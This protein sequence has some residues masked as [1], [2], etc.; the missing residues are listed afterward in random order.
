MVTS[1]LDGPGQVVFR[2]APSRVAVT[3]RCAAP[4]DSVYSILCADGGQVARG[5]LSR[6]Q[7]G[8]RISVYYGDLRL[9]R[10][11][12]RAQLPQRPPPARRPHR[13]P[14]IVAGYLMVPDIVASWGP[15]V[16]QSCLPVA[17][18]SK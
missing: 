8:D 11:P 10:V 9:R 18:K 13:S 4:P 2:R 17:G 12:A 15:Q 16:D 6:R 14:S 1:M 7:R 5:P 3:V